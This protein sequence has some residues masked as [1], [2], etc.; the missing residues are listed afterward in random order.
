LT[1]RLQGLFSEVIGQ[2]QSAF[3]LGRSLAENVLFTTEMV[4]GYNRL[5]IS[6]WGMLKVD[7]RKA[8]DS[9]K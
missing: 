4:H 9:V 6:P 7:L 2:S 1:G 3:L 8:F 5:H